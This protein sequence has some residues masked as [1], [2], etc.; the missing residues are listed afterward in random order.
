M[1]S[2]LNRRKPLHCCTIIPDNT[3]KC[4]NTCI[5][6]ILL[7]NHEKLYASTLFFVLGFTIFIV[8]VF[9]NVQ[10]IFKT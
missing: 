6:I 10:F 3:A 5:L 4:T 7:Y 1:A 9:D 2:F 8:H